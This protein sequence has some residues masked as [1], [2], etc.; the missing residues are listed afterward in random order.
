MTRLTDHQLYI[1]DRQQALARQH[2]SIFTQYTDEALQQKLSSLP[3]PRQFQW[4][5]EQGH[6]YFTQT[7][8]ILRGEVA[9]LR[10]AWSR[11]SG[12]PDPLDCNN[13]RAFVDKLRSIPEVFA[14]SH[15]YQR[16]PIACA[17]KRYNEFLVQHREQAESTLIVSGTPYKVIKK[18]P[19]Y[20]SGW[21]CDQTAWVVGTP[22]GPKLVMSNHGQLH[23]ADA[24]ELEGK[25]Q[26][27][28][29]AVSAS[30]EL[31]ELVLQ[32]VRGS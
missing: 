31:L 18:A 4:I 14:D 3:P 5:H 32:P 9:V 1:L 27:Y 15:W 20:H 7:S 23:F 30:Q 24:A 10:K 19:V 6:L 28:L 11:E 17:L 26:E 21:E 13:N 2:L 29:E 16:A 25:I 22:E 12:A 8:E